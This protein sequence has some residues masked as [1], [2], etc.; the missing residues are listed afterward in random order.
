MW[1]DVCP[2]RRIAS[3]FDSNDDRPL[4]VRLR[5]RRAIVASG[6][7]LCSMLVAAEA[8]ADGGPITEEARA[9]FSAGVSFLQDP[10]G[11]RYDDVYRE[12]KAAYAV[13][14]SWKIL[15]NLGIAAMKL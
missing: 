11:A 12:F 5:M 3:A 9:H 1:P 7:V 10:D 6:F 13:S 8:A 15:G 14:P 4:L 2:G